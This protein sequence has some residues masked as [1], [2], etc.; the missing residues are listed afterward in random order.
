MTKDASVDRAKRELE[1]ELADIAAMY[2]SGQ[3]QGTSAVRGISQR[4]LPHVDSSSSPSVSS[5]DDDGRAI[6]LGLLVDVARCFRSRVLQGVGQLVDHNADRKGLKMSSEEDD[7]TD[8]DDE[9]EGEDE[10]GEGKATVTDGLANNPANPG[11]E[12]VDIIEPRAYRVPC[13]AFAGGNKCKR[14]VFRIHSTFHTPHSTTPLITHSLTRKIFPIGGAGVFRR[15][16][17][18]P[19]AHRQSK[20]CTK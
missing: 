3:G 17:F 8:D 10:D 6:Q 20:K 11:D 19:G 18:V 4:D 15:C 7:D 13:P 5:V 16:H 14:N 9:E 2:T 12:V 1:G